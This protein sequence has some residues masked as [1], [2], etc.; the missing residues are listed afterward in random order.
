M[1]F[2]QGS[3]Q[4]QYMKAFI[5]EV[6]TYFINLAIDEMG[7]KISPFWQGVIIFKGL[8]AALDWCA[9]VWLLLPI[10]ITIAK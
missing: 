9:E 10:I 6:E 4:K 7:D 5:T 8:N 3:L 1:G 2:A